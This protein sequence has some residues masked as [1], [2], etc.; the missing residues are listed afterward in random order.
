MDG[1]GRAFF[2]TNRAWGPD[3][4]DGQGHCM[5]ADGGSTWQRFYRGNSGL[6]TDT[7]WD[8][9][10][11]AQG[12]PWVAT[13]NACELGSPGGVYR[14]TPSKN[15]WRHWGTADDPSGDDIRAVAVGQDVLWFGVTD[16]GLDGFA[17]NWQAIGGAPSSITALASAPGV[18]WVGS[19]TQGVWKFTGTA[20]TQYHTGNSDLGG[21]GISALVAIP[22]ERLW[23]GTSSHGIAYFD[24]S[25]WTSYQVGTSGL[26][27]DRVRALAQDVKGRLWVGTH[28]GLSVYTPKDDAWS[29]IPAGGE[30]YPN[31]SVAALAAGEK[32]V[33]VGTAA[34]IGVYD[35][36]GWS[37][38][39]TET[40][41]PSDGA[42]PDR[43]WLLAGLRRLGGQHLRGPHGRELQW[44]HRRI[45][46]GALHRRVL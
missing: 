20:W 28:G 32:H 16:H 25:S 12:H 9:A 26:V 13:G 41:L 19:G 34:G 40:G 29:T 5:T 42:D 21:D 27:D 10:A 46:T 14:Y 23:A 33:W 15:L 6:T 35:G 18:L 8:L 38:H 45:G 17:P 44:A 4:L 22:E 36:K 30:T 1:T 7:V 24:G 11:D 2:G 43:P 39:T 3:P 31:A 37:L